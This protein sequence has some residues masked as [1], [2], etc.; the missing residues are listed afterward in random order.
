VEST[1]VGDCA[2]DGQ[3]TID[4]LLTGVNIALGNLPVS[5]CPAFDPSG[6]G[7]VTISDLVTGVN[8][9]L[10]GCPG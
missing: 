9:A 5:E 6:D 7:Q 2:G 8:N 4:D 1:C 3:V 10:N